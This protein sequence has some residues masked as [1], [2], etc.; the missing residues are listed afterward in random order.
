M[1][2]A[3]IDILR[4]MSH[5]HGVVKHFTPVQCVHLDVRVRKAFYPCTMCSLRC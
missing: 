2:T 5:V 3:L 1:L 4:Y